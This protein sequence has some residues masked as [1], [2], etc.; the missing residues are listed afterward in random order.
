M[1]E[2]GK[3]QQ[4]QKKKIKYIVVGKAVEEDTKAKAGRGH[5]DEHGERG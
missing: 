2:K 1:I 3:L 5:Q 4:W